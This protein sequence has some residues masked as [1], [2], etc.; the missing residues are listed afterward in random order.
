MWHIKWITKSVSVSQKILKLKIIIILN[1][2]LSD[3]R[4][5]GDL[6][7]HSTNAPSLLFF[8]HYS[9]CW[10]ISVNCIGVNVISCQFLKL[11]IIIVLNVA[12]SNWRF[13]GELHRHNINA[14][15]HFYIFQFILNVDV[16]VSVSYHVSICV[17][18]SYIVC[19]IK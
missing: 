16:S 1:V 7:R 17:C 10:C 18:A 19:S 11:K 5:V 9:S 6:H 15:N 2:A 14:F 12:P 13:V 8:S 4:F 3:W